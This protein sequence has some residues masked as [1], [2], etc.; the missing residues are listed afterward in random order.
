M[1]KSILRVSAVVGLLGLV[2]CLVA[3]SSVTAASVTNG[4]FEGGAVNMGFSGALD[5]VADF[6]PNGWTR[7][8]TFSGGVIENSAIS[9]VSDNGP[10]APGNWALDCSRSLGG[11]SGDW[12]AVEQTLSIDASLY[13]SL[14]LS[15]DAKVF[16]HNLEAGGW[17]TPAFEWPVVLDI[18]YTTTGGASQTWR[19]GWFLNP[20]GDSGSGGPVND[21]GQG[22]IPFYNDQV[23]PQG[24]WV[25]TAFDLF[26]ELPQLGTIDRLRVGGSGWDFEGRADNIILTGV[27]IPEPTTLALLGLGLAGTAIRRRR[28]SRT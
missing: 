22:L 21:P 11:A 27:P 13:T 14:S 19:Y 6:V 25:T 4:L 17:V 26:T 16:A 10:S 1:R 20:P 18:V 12:T 23:V 28:R 3:P 7:V 9:V 2:G 8:E 15:I 5:G 24:Q